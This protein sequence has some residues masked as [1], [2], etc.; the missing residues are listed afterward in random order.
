MV[1]SSLE[2]KNAHKA[3]C[4]NPEPS[5]DHTTGWLQLCKQHILSVFLLYGIALQ[6]N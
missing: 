6:T 2:P 4:Q 3:Y 1:T 5:N